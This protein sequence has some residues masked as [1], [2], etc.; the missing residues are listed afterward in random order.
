[1]TWSFSDGI[2]SP[3]S[4]L[5]TASAGPDGEAAYVHRNANSSWDHFNYGDLSRN[6]FSLKQKAATLRMSLQH[7]QH[8]WLRTAGEAVFSTNFFILCLRFVSYWWG[9]GG[10]GE[11][12]SDL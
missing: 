12:S 4:S 7:F 1:M 9:S 3:T 11:E 8:I 5:L 6:I 2:L 10:A